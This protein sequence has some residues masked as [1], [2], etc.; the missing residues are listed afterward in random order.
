MTKQLSHLHIETGPGGWLKAFWHRKGGAENVI[1]ARLRP[2]KTKRHA[3]A[4]IGLHASKDS[5]PPW[6]S[7][8]LVADVPDRFIVLAVEA[9][10]VFRS[11][12][13]EAI[14]H[15]QPD[16]LDAAFNSIYRERPRTPLVHPGRARLDADFFRDVAAAYREAVAAGLPP[17]KTMAADSGIP[18]GTIARWVARARADGH[19]PEAERGK[20]TV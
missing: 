20:V 16:D 19:L 3:W 8:D 14:D 12:L 18:Q 9:S 4:I 15:P 7:P 1:Y 13:L 5:K 17:L 10:D 11:A 6:L 2:P